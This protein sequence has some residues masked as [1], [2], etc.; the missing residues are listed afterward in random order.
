MT[1][2]GP[3]SHGSPA[4]YASTGWW[5]VAI[6][7]AHLATTGVFY[8]KSL[9]ELTSG[10]LLGALDADPQDPAARGA[11]FWYA[12]SGVTLL[13]LGWSARR[14]EASGR[15]PSREFAV[16]LNT[17]GL[18]GVVASP[19]SPFW[20]VLGIGLVAAARRRRSTG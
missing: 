11:S 15:P 17:L 3:P 7:V 5:C 10:P 6:A 12:A 13:G 9:R 20:A 14:A 19:R 8:G 18:A 4:W 16:C 1:T 2:D